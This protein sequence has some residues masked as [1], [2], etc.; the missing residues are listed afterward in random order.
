MKNM[1]LRSPV[2][3]LASLGVLTVALLAAGL[4]LHAQAPGDLRVALV[5]GNAAYAG[6]A[7]LTNPGNDAKAMSEALRGLGFTVIEVRDGSKAQ[8]A[9]AIIKVKDTLQG[10]QGVGMF[11][12]AGHAMQLDWRNYMLPV[13]AK[14]S[15]ASEVA[16]K[17][18]DL[19]QVIEAFKTAGNRMNIVVLDACR[20]NPFATTA[21]GKG[22]AQLDAPPGTFLAYA[23]APG[24]VAEDGDA[25]S[26]NGLYTQFLLQ[27]L[28]KPA[29]KIEDVF[30]RVRLNVRQQ[31]QGR[32]IPWESTSLED[33]FFFNAGL[34]PM[35]KLG[36]SD[37]EKAF[38]DEKSQW[39]KIKG[40]NNASDFYAFLQ[41]YPNANISGLAQS[42]IERLQKSRVTV[43]ADK[44]GLKADSFFDTLRDGDRYEFLIK[45]GFRAVVRGKASIEMKAR[46]D[47][48]IE[49]VSSDT[50]LVGNARVNRGGFLIS[51]GR[52]TYDPPWSIA[53][54]GEL[55][56]GGKA[57][58]RTILTRH[59]DG[60]KEWVDI[61]SKVIGRETLKTE[62]GMIETIKLEVN[63]YSQSGE[64]TKWSAWYDPEWGYSVK[65]ISE[66][67]GRSGGTNIYLR[68]MTARSRKAS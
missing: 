3:R 5:I 31:S 62:F 41:Q 53:P 24:N 34:K 13:D 35:Q 23:T 26:A 61:E 9:E 68:E 14:L 10:K 11:Y 45:D 2:S 67:R 8:M 6:N 22:L 27:E 66:S 12:Y 28:K 44:S 32:Q 37:K 56:L 43:V 19:S 38:T 57:N 16:E 55:K 49:G 64:Q 48:E 15:K 60:G 25:K 21:S 46:G 18:V 7:S 59:S 54:N 33:D 52:G 4:P 17:T 30:K 36:D 20:D 65:F 63:R 58:T 40:S 51:D 47:D 50:S 29:A 39:D 42:Q 1:Y